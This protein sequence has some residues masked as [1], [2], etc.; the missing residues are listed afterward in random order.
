MAAG[1]ACNRP[2]VLLLEKGGERRGYGTALHML[3]SNFLNTG[4]AGGE[5]KH[6]NNIVKPSCND[7]IS[8]T[9][10]FYVKFTNN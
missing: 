10:R 2:G 9:P 7:K 5:K 4:S 8:L 3:G 1:R 6:C